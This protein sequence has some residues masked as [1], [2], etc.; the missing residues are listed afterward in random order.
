MDGGSELPIS[1]EPLARLV[2]FAVHKCH[3]DAPE[4]QEIPDIDHKRPGERRCAHPLATGIEDLQSR[5]LV[6]G[7][8]SEAFVVLA[9]SVSEP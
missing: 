2:E 6:L 8:Y 1:P 5:H 4:S 7:Q 9:P 3:P